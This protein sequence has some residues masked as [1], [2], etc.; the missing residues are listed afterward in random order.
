M[1][2]KY[3]IIEINGIDITVDISLLIKTEEL[4]FNATEMAKPYDKTP[5]NF[6]RLEATEEYIN[7]L[8]T[9]SG[10][11]KNFKGDLKSPLSFLNAEKSHIN[12]IDDLV[13]VKKGKYGGTWLR[14]DLAIAFAR[15]LNPF[16]GV[17]LDKWTIFKL[18]EEQSR[19]RSRLEAK[20]GYLP[21]TNAILRNHSPAKPYHFSNEADL[22]NRIVLGM[23]A[24]KFREEYGVDNVREGCTAAQLQ[25]IVRLQTINT[26]LV[27]IGMDYQERKE[28]LERCHRNELLLLGEVV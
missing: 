10:C 27:E 28:H 12:N 16:F 11:N 13:R 8:I 24:K 25:E 19:K 9:L 5:K 7:A 3:E 20:T 23:P 2:T 6:L 15:W 21:M 22:I 14:K 1:N 18:K 4:F 26:G 17:M